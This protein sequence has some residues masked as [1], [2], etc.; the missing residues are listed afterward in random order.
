MNKVLITVITILFAL[1]DAGAFRQIT[2]TGNIYDRR[3]AG[4]LPDT[5]IRI[6]TPDSVL[7]ART[8]ASKDVHEVYATAVRT[9]KTGGFSVELSDSIDRYLLV[10]S[11]EGF[12]PHSET[13]DLSPLGTREYEL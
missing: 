13:V 9:V 3:T 8:I 10:A 4:H 1:F 11:H 12:E 6:L 7:I 2:V 5:E